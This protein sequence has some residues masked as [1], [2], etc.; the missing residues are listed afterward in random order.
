LGFASRRSPVRSF[1]F[2]ALSAHGDMWHYLKSTLICDNA[3]VPGTCDTTRRRVRAYVADGSHASYPQSCDSVC[4]RTTSEGSTDD[5][6]EKNYDGLVPW[7]ANDDADALKPFPEA[8]GWTTVGNPG[9]TDWPGYWGADFEVDSPGVRDAYKRPDIAV[10]GLCTER[11]TDPGVTNC[12]GSEGPTATP[13]SMSPLSSSTA[14]VGSCC[15]PWSGPHVVVSICSPRRLRS[16]LKAGTI[17]RADRLDLSGSAIRSRASAT[18]R[19]I[20]QL[21]GNPLRPSDR[22]AITGELRA[23]TQIGSASAP[24][25]GAS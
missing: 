4:E 22:V 8:V 1:S 6:L 2:A 19:G 7:G 17:A 18:G 5:P 12:D 20:A 14:A 13:R 21:V 16:A 24:E 9:W 23:G 3:I 25:T 11:Y 15:R 10:L